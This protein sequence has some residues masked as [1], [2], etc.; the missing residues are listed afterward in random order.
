LTNIFEKYQQELL[1]QVSNKKLNH[2]KRKGEK[3]ERVSQDNFSCASPA[4][5]KL[6]LS[7]PV[8]E[9]LGTRAPCIRSIHNHNAEK[10]LEER[11][12]KTTGPRILQELCK[13]LQVFFLS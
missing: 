13:I 7:M 8:S 6:D 3:L 1:V 10:R 9:T 5:H 12:L 4:V 2:E 11:Q